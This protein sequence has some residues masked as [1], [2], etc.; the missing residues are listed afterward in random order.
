MTE[1]ERICQ[2]RKARHDYEII[3]IVEAGIVLRGSEVKSILSRHC[4]LDAAYAIVSNNEV[5]LLGC[6]IEPFKQATV[7][8]HEPLR[9]RKLLLHRNQ[10]QKLAEKTKAKGFTLIPLSIYRE[11][12]KIKI[13]LAVCKGRQLHDKRQAIK[14]REAKK[15]IRS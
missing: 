5:F 4:S 11:R 8:N 1:S 14:E 6:N 15:E 3:E 10:I 12:G 9:Q 2:N 7:F 13:E